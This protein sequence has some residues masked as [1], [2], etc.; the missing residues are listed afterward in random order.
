[1]AGTRCS[2]TCPTALEP[3]P[4]WDLERRSRHRS[5]SLW[6]PVPAPQAPPPLALQLLLQLVEEAP[7]SPLSDE[8]LGGALDHPRLVQAQG[9]EADRILGVVLAP[10]P[11]RKLLNGLEG[12]VVPLHILLVHEEAGGPLRLK[13]ADVG[14]F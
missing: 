4:A 6:V 1:M 9:I 14:C 13:R 3:H 11:I 10:L 2:P 8:L 5:E 7:V 12:I